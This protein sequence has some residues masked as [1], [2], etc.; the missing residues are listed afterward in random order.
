MRDERQAKIFA[1]TQQAFTVG[2]ATSLPQRGLRLLE[3]AIEAFQSAGGDAAMA[4]KL[5]DYVFSRPVGELGQELG[6]IGVCILALAA[7]AGLSADEE[8]QREVERVLAKPIEEF[9]RRN[10][11]KSAAGFLMLAPSFEDGGKLVGDNPWPRATQ[12][13]AATP[14][15]GA[16]AQGAAQAAGNVAE[17]QLGPTPDRA[18]RPPSS[19]SLEEEYACDCAAN[20]CPVA[21]DPQRGPCRGFCGCRGCARGYADFMDFE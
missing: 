7:A 12:Q 17:P 1:W 20:R 10:A 16:T 21:A 13:G 19:P 2:Q 11:A 15:Q 4:H 9:K 14:G 8:E 18:E 5:V 6:G 3:E